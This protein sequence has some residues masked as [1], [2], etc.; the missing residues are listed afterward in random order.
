MPDLHAPLTS[1]CPCSPVCGPSRGRRPPRPRCGLGARWPPLD[2]TAG[3][4]FVRGPSARRLGPPR[5]PLGPF[6]PALW[7][8]S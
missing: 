5:W 2:Y 8:L 4:G 3:L 7:A 6:G 1:K